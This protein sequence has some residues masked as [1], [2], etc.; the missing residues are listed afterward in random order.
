MVLPSHKLLIY[1][2][3]TV[4]MYCGGVK[5]S[6]GSIFRR[7]SGLHNPLTVAISACTWN[8]IPSYLKRRQTGRERARCC[9]QWKTKCWL[10]QETRIFWGATGVEIQTTRN[11]GACVVYSIGSTFRVGSHVVCQVDSPAYLGCPITNSSAS[12]LNPRI[13]RPR[14]TAYGNH[15]TSY[16][17]LRS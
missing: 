2:L 9:P 7:H 13:F 14:D 17:T 16:L 10:E 11:S 4:T 15:F 6:A 1:C 3:K 5:Q 8:R 12:P